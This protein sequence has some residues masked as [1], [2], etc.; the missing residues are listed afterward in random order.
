MAELW[1]SR[2]YG[3]TRRTFKRS[4]TAEHIAQLWKKTKDSMQRNSTFAHLLAAVDITYLG[5]DATN[6]T[7]DVIKSVCTQ[8]KRVCNAFNKAKKTNAFPQAKLAPWVWPKRAILGAKRARSS[9]SDSDF[10]A[11]PSA[12]RDP[13]V[14]KRIREQNATQ[15]EVP[16]HHS[17]CFF[18]PVSPSH[19]HC[20]TTHILS[21][22]ST[23]TI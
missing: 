4:L 15:A 22:H 21:H 11:P 6:L 1:A 14:R 5:P 19:V 13:E 20:T 18:Y 7:L 12:R 10:H 17:M 8:T 2:L 23:R 16:A 9:P 3:G